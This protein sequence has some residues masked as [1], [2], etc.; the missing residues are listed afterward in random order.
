MWR[1][2]G[3]KAVSLLSSPSRTSRARLPKAQGEEAAIREGGG[4]GK[5]PVRAP[6]PWG[7]RSPVWGLTVL[8]GEQGLGREGGWGEASGDFKA[9][10]GV[11]A[12]VEKL[13]LGRAAPR[14]SDQVKAGGSLCEKP[15]FPTAG[16]DLLMTVW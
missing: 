6:Q 15:G 11:A 9:A 13:C 7:W 8:P 5:P 4:R 16:N 1:S 10:F 12:V 3:P 2:V 14:N